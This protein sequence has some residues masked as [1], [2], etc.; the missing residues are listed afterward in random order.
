MKYYFDKKGGAV[1]KNFAF[2][3]SDTPFISV[4]SFEYNLSQ[5]AVINM[6]NTKPLRS[7]Q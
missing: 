7:K 3:Q 2:N 1:I 5:K 6:N 4:G